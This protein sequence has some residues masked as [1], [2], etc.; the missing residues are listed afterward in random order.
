MDGWRFSAALL[1]A[2]LHAGWNAVVKASAVPAQTMT[3][4]M[5]A[6]TLLAL[7][8]LVWTGL[9]PSAA[10]PWIALSTVLNRCAVGSLLRAYALGSFGLVYAFARAASILLAVPLAAALSG[11]RLTAP[12]L[13]GVG[14][15]CAALAWLALCGSRRDPFPRW[16][17]IWTLAAGASTAGYVVCDAQGVRSSGSPWAYG[18]SVTV[19]NAA[20][21]AWPQRRTLVAG[22]VLSR[23]WPIALPLAAASTLSYLLILWVWT[24]APIALSL[25]LRDTSALFGMVIAVLWLREPL[26]ASRVLALALAVAGIAFLRLG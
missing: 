17:L 9:P 4:Q 19:T 12:G 8:G 26:T 18:F 11:E 23:L 3:A 16:A 15:V 22:R 13:A 24:R 25:A 14:L 5:L 10:W 21:M 2:V 6:C 20:A 1:S 7:P